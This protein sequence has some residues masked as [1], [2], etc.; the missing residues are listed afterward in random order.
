MQRL[1]LLALL[2]L[3]ACSKTPSRG[4]AP[5]A[6]ASAAIAAASASAAAVAAAPKAAWFVG[7]WK[8]D[9]AVARRDST[10]TTKEGGP[11]NWEK[12]DGKKLAGPGSLQLTVDAAGDLTGSLSG[13]LGELLL[14]GRIDGEELRA[15]LVA[16]SEDPTAI[17]NGYIALLHQGD[18]LKGTLSAATGDA[19][20]LRQAV[21]E[22][23]KAAP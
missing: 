15:S 11:A 5:V 21:L 22:L 6:S 20:T 12:D 10:T 14:R 13:A 16:K 18:A 4:A 23:K 17:H 19:Q 7:T 3:S 9:F 8:G 1:S 2:L